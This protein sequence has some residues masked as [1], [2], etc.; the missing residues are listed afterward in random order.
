MMGD[1]GSDFCARDSFSRACELARWAI[2]HLAY[3]PTWHQHLNTPSSPHGVFGVGGGAIVQM[4]SG[5]D[6]TDQAIST[7]GL[8]IPPCGGATFFIA[9]GIDNTTGTITF[10]ADTLQGSGPGVSG[11]GF[12]L[13]FIF[14]AAALGA[15]PRSVSNLIL[16]DSNGNLISG[17]TQDGSVVVGVIRRNPVLC[18]WRE[19]ASY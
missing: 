5:V 10:N 7:T 6:P 12:L 11:S 13:Q 3:R 4:A 18:S 17:W 9:G 15:S 16:Q 8:Y 19:Q 14:T 2:N 1:K